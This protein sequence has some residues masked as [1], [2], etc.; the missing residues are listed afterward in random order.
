M[1]AMAEPM[2]D[3]VDPVRPA[4]AVDVPALTRMLVRSYMDDPVA[5]WICKSSFVRARLLETLYSARLRQLLL[6]E[7][8]WTNADHAS[9]AVWVP[10]ATSQ[11]SVRPTATLMRCLLSP[12]VTVR[13]PLLAVGFRAM[14]RAH[15]LSPPHWYLS[16]LG[17]DPDS[18]GHGYGSAVLRP[19][20]ERCDAD[21]VGA[22]L[23][24][25]KPRNIDF[26]ARF[27]FRVMG[28]LQLPY[29]PKM[30]P[31]WREPNETRG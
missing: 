5:V 27:G 18:Q 20:L 21:G 14:Q 24:S 16:L 30:W 22:Y 9:A 29:G 1:A 31:M 3:G 23:E 13:L 8:V 6:H 19:V 26:Y 25:S 12:R 7:G 10:P 17:T 11:P 2:R 4:Q 28:E 15:P